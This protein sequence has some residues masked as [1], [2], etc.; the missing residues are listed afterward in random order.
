MSSYAVTGSARGI[1]VSPSHA[2]SQ[3]ARTNW[4]LIV[5]S[6][7]LSTSSAATQLTQYSPLFGTRILH[8]EFPTSSGLTFTSC[9]PISLMCRSWRLVHWHCRK[10]VFNE[11]HTYR[12]PLKKYP[13]SQEANLMCWLTTERSSTLRALLIALTISEFSAS[14]SWQILLLTINSLPVRNKM[15]RALRSPII[16]P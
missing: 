14:S 12:L 10:E 1:G 3:S 7:N 8:K 11:F 4:D 2:R 9:R 6:L 15:P 5:F 13:K 16:N